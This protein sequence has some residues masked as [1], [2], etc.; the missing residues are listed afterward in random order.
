MPTEEEKMLRELFKMPT[1]DLSEIKK[2]H[3]K[4]LKE[5]FQNPKAAIDASKHILKTL[6]SLAEKMEKLGK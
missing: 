6:S 4:I 2:K 3:P 1:A 5:V